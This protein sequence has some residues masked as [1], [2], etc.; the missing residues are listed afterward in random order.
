[1]WDV[2]LTV[3]CVKANVEMEQWG[4]IEGD[5]QKRERMK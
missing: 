4:K 1:M 2:P 5:V 3:F